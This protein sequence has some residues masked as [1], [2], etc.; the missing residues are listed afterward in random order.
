MIICYGSHRALIHLPNIYLSQNSQ[1]EL[2]R[3]YIYG[4]PFI[5]WNKHFHF[6]VIYSF[7]SKH[8]CTHIISFG[9]IYKSSSSSI[10]DYLALW[11]RV[12]EGSRL[13]CKWEISHRK[14]LCFSLLGKQEGNQIED[15][16]VHFELASV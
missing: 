9:A 11:Q 4:D 8:I 16:C 13:L 10:C 6:L 3:E 1:S 15:I 14:L 2:L 12:K 5:D 7:F